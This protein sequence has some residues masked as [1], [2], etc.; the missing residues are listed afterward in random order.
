MSFEIVKE[1]AIIPLIKIL[2]ELD[3]DA[4]CLSAECLA[5]LSILKIA[6]KIY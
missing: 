1:G 6:R 5:N 2:N 4:K 3:N